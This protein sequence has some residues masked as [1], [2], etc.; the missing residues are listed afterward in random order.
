MVLAFGLVGWLVGGVPYEHV[1][2]CALS[3]LFFYTIAAVVSLAPFSLF[4][5]G[6]RMA[7]VLW[8]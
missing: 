8:W 6:G 1:E 2:Y 3:S 4:S 7:S 5:Y